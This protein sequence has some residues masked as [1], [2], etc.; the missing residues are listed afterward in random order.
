MV[1]GNA[2]WKKKEKESPQQIWKHGFVSNIMF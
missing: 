2:A 1:E